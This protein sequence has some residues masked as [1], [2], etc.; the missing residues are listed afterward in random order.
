M[1][2]SAL[3]SDIA[4]HLQQSWRAM[5]QN[6]ARGLLQAMAVSSELPDSEVTVLLN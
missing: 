5:I 6:D 1:Q 2:V 4:F 3:H